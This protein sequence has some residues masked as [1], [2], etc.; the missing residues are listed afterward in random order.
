VRRFQQGVPGLAPPDARAAAAWYGAAAQ[1]GDVPARRRLGDLHFAGALGMPPGAPDYARALA[2]YAAL[3]DDA[4]AV[5]SLG[6]MHE[7]GLG[8]PRNVT[9][10]LRL[11]ARAARLGRATTRTGPH[12]SLPAPEGRFASELAAAALTAREAARAVAA[13]VGGVWS[14]LRRSR[15]GDTM[16]RSQEL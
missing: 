12:A 5:H 16:E 7:H 13:T 1:L 15:R 10:A 9:E 3:P 4:E 2:E 6:Y 11:Y 14:S 8:A